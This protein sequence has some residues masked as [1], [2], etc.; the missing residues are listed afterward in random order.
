MLLF[1]KRIES[2]YASVSWNKVTS[3]RNYANKSNL[4]RVSPAFIEI[5]NVLVPSFNH[6]DGRH[7]LHPQTSADILEFWSSG[8]VLDRSIANSWLYWS[9]VSIETISIIWLMISLALMS[10]GVD[11][12]SGYLHMA[13]DA[14]E[15]PINPIDWILV[16]DERWTVC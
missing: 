4:W 1:S 11:N 14:N 9:R 13:T 7:V 8:D 3:N 12:S 2:N 16:M 15:E 10:L 6:Q 5:L